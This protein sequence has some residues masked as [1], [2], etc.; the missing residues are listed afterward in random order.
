PG[1]AD[2]F[3]ALFG[4]HYRFELGESGPVI[5]TADGE[6]ATLPDK[7]GTRPANFTE[8]D[9]YALVDACAS[10]GVLASVTVASRASGCGASG[11]RGGIPAPSGQPAQPA[12]PAPSPY[13]LK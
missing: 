10:A 8:A 13:G 9:V 6:P 1:T 7:D 2:V 4:R 3:A 11:S 12:E 5:L